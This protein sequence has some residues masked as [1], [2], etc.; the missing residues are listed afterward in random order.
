MSNKYSE[1]YPNARYYVTNSS[2]RRSCCVRKERWLFDL[3][4]ELWGVNVQP[5][6]DLREFSCLHCIVET[7]CSYFGIGSTSRWTSFSRI[8]DSAEDLRSV[9][10]FRD[11][12]YQCNLR[13][14]YGHESHS[15]A[16]SL[17]YTHT[18]THTHTQRSYRLRRFGCSGKSCT[19]RSHRC[20]CKCVLQ[21]LRLCAYAWYC[22]CH[23]ILSSLGHGTYQWTR[24]GRYRTVPIWVLR[25]RDDDDAQNTSRTSWSYDLLP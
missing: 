20:G 18:H 25:R 13:R 24:C 23:W 14:T 9:D 1:G 21:T 2:I 6:S 10:V 7:S 22:W 5:L 11:V 12:W 16:H 4:P 17:T 15:L 19:P 8:S 3:D